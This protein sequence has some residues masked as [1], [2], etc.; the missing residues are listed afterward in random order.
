MCTHL[1]NVQSDTNTYHVYEE[2]GGWVDTCN[3]WVNRHSP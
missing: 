2:S 3:T 1:T